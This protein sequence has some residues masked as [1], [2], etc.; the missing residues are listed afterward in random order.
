MVAIASSKNV[1]GQ[2]NPVEGYERKGRLSYLRVVPLDDDFNTAF[3][4]FDSIFDVPEHRAHLD[5]IIDFGIVVETVML[6]AS[7]HTGE[8][9][10]HLANDIEDPLTV[11]KIVRKVV[12][13]LHKLDEGQGVSR[14]HALL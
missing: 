5:K 2:A 3:G 8:N 4:Q 11:T 10:V 1:L 12:D 6:G 9:R 7:K 14:V 13:L